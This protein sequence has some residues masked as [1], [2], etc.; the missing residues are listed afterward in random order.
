[1]DFTLLYR[2]KKFNL[3]VLLIFAKAPFWGYDLRSSFGEATPILNIKTASCCSNTM[4]NTMV[5]FF[6]LAFS[7]L[8]MMVHAS[9]LSYDTVYD[10]SSTSMSTVAC[11]H[12]LQARGFKTFGSLPHFPFI[13]AVPAIKGGNSVNCGT[14]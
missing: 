5:A 10:Y 6:S 14:Y 12:G 3:L 1:M 9:T 4:P 2:S 8:P 13:G 11:S 7:L